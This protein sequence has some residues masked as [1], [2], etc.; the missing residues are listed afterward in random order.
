MKDWKWVPK[1]PWNQST[2]NLQTPPP[3]HY[4]LTPEGQLVFIVWN[5]DYGSG[6]WTSLQSDQYLYTWNGLQV[7]RTS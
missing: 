6:V 7:K 1:D 2:Y 3:K 4:L 5:L